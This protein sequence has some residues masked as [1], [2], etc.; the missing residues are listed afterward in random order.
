MEQAAAQRLPTTVIEA[1]S[2]EAVDRFPARIARIV[3]A[4]INRL[5]SKQKQRGLTSDD[6]DRLRKASDL[7][8]S[9]QKRLNRRT[10]ASRSTNGARQPAGSQPAQETALEKLA[11][12]Q[13]ERVGVDDHL[14]RAHTPPAPVESNDEPD[15]PTT[16]DPPP[17]TPLDA[18]RRVAAKHGVDLRGMEDRPV[19]RSRQEAARKARAALGLLPLA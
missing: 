12:E 15:V 10:P 3:D 17:Q 7:S 16:P 1:E 2:A 14:L 5:D 18:V 19:E 4:E 6:Y 11:R 13:G 8:L 9:L